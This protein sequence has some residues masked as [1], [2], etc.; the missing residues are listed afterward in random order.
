M[1]TWRMKRKHIFD[2]ETVVL[3]FQDEFRKSYESRYDHRLYVVLMVA[4]R[5]RI[6]EVL[7]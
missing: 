4:K 7:S 3:I 2:A 6:G 5:M 1:L